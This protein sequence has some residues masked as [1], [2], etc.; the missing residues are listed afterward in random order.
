MATAI[1]NYGVAQNQ[2]KSLIFPNDQEQKEPYR[3]YIGLLTQAGTAA[4]TVVEK[5]NTM[6]ATPTL[7]RTSAGVYTFTLTGY[8]ISGQIGILIA[9]NLASNGKINARRTSDNV[10]TIETFNSAGAATDALITDVL[11]ELKVW[12]K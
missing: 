10:I 1:P 7:A 11:I 3:V 5:R 2:N 12:E 8:I 9:N 6:F 4:P